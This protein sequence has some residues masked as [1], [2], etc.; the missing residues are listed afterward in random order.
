[1]SNQVSKLLKLAAEFEKM[2]GVMSEQP[3]A[4]SNARAKM[5]KIESLNVGAV[6]QLYKLAPRMVQLFKFLDNS[7]DK[8]YKKYVFSDKSKIPGWQ[9]F[10]NVESVHTNI[11]YSDGGINEL[12]EQI[13]DYAPLF[14]QMK[15]KSPG[16]AFKKI[17][18]I[19]G[20]VYVLLERAKKLSEDESLAA[21]PQEQSVANQLA[22]VLQS[23]YS[24]SSSI[25]DNILKVDPDAS[26]FTI[27]E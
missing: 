6:G 25:Q 9:K 2:A 5:K 18:L 17:K 12:H 8:I 24:L 22:Q 4:T 7:A 1:M 16:E 14:Y 23:V 20:N 27:S 11:N 3:Q 10:F 19:V 21:Y 13:M 15:F 26:S